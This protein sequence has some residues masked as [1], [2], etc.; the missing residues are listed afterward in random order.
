VYFKI[1]NLTDQATECFL[2]LRLF[3][4]ELFVLKDSIFL[5]GNSS[6]EMAFVADGR[7]IRLE[8]DQH[9]DFSVVEQAELYN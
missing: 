4:D 5:E 9:P 8:A 7:T 1:E 2:P 3:R 6:Q